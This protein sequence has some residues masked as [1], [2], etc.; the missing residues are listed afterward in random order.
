MDKNRG[1]QYFILKCHD[2]VVKFIK[3]CKRYNM[4]IDVIDSLTRVTFEEYYLTKH[5]RFKEGDLNIPRFPMEN[6]DSLTEEH[7]NK[8]GWRSVLECEWN[9]GRQ[10]WT[11]SYKRHFYIDDITHPNFSIINSARQITNEKL[12]EDEDGALIPI[13]VDMNEIIENYNKPKE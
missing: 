1:G 6:N 12:E 4:R 8:Y 7:F 10:I 11:S 5:L 9:V 13:E 3:M 2:D